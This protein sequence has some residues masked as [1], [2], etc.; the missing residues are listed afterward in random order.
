MKTTVLIFLLLLIIGCTPKPEKTDNALAERI[1][2]IEN[3]IEPNIQIEGDSV[4]NYNIEERMKMLDIVGVSIAVLR[5]EQIEWAKG[6]GIADST[7]NRSV[8]NE[9]MFFAGSVSKAVAALHAHQLAEQGII[10][11]DSN[12]NNYLKSWKLPDNEFTVK[13]KVTTRRILNHTAGLTV[14]GFPGYNKGDTIPSLAEILD[15]KGN[16]DA[17]RVYKEPGES[18]MYSGGGYTVMQ[19]MMTDLAKKSFPDIMQEQVLTPLGMTSSTF[20]NPL[21]QKYHA[22]AATGYLENGDEVED[23][24]SIHPEMAAAGLWAT[25]SQ[26]LLWAK[27]IQNTYQKKKNGLLKTGTVDEML[28]AGMNEQGV[29]PEVTKHTFGHDGADKGFRA[30]LTAWKEYPIAVAIMT[31]SE[32]SSFGNEVLLSIA[33]EYGLPGIEA[34]VRKTISRSVEQRTPMVGKYK[35]AEMGEATVAI[36]G[37]GLEVTG[38][39]T[40]LPI[41]LLPES[42][43]VY[44]NK[45]SGT[46][47]KFHMKDGAVTALQIW[48]NI[49]EKVE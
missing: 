4:P 29:G 41:M 9:T 8:T 3:G 31:N 5:E 45:A 17:V 25:P 22:I 14:W 32:K 37:N 2:R 33:K 21:P 35:F 43:S 18:W 46:Y 44:F 24:W 47:Y 16:T 30:W 1:A 27:D 34:D 23:K 40:N 28:T 20:E 36:K 10:S 19:L 6:Y 38:A 49:A 13:E 26:L 11:L 7:E 15:G 42:D 39:F 12:V 48:N